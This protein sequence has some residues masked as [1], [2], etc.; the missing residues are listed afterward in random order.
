MTMEGSKKGRDNGSCSSGGGGGDGGRPP[1]PLT[2]TGCRGFNGARFGLDSPCS[3][4]K[5]SLVRHPSLVN[6]LPPF[7]FV[8]F[9]FLIGK[10]PVLDILFLGLSFFFSSVIWEIFSRFSV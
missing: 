6:L 5:K 7:R 8:K 3:S 9:V 4:Y 2:I 10:V 1:N